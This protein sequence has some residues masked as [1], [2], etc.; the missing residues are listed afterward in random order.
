[1]FPP[2]SDVFISYWRRDVEF[3]SKF[4]SALQHRGRTP[5]VDLSW[6]GCIWGFAADVKPFAE[7]AVLEDAANPGY[8][9]TRGLARALTGDVDG[10]VQD[11]RAFADW[12]DRLDRQ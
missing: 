5:W 12:T 7:R 1:M 4:S 11:F 10:A 6:F 2:M 3:V 9:D 8:R